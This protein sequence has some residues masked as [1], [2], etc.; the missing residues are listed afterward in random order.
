M[1]VASQIFPFFEIPNWIVRA[2]VLLL[3]LGFPVALVLAWAF[4]LTPEGMKGAEDV[5]LSKSIRRKT[6]RKL[7][8][9][10]IAVLLLVIGI[11]LF[12]RLH[13]NVSPAVSSS[14]QKSIAVLPFENLS[15]EKG[16]AYFAEGVQEEIL[17]R[18]SKIADLK[19]ISHTST[20]QF[21]SKPANLSE[22]A[23]EL[24]VVNLLEGSV[25]KIAH[26][27]P[28]NAQLIRAATDEHIWAE[29]YNRKLDDVFGVEGEVATAIADQLKAKLTG[30]E[31]KALTEK[32]TQNVA[33]YDAYLHGRSLE[34]EVYLFESNQQ[35]AA[36]YARAVQ[37]DPKFALAW[38]HLG[39]ARSLLFVSGEDPNIY[40]ATAVKQAAE[41]AM[42]LQPDLAEAWVALGAYRYRV[43]RDFAGALKAF[44]EGQK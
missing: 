3:I 23:K 20:Q 4:E 42:A 33:A 21:Q 17:T 26:E 35:P 41:E 8:F 22:I 6:G 27:V 2:V 15:E 16:N 28:M 30:A 24:G 1:Q 43:L 37:L 36:D 19:V 5:E 14:L 31:E 18:L 44:E 39:V 9:F 25:H 38:A 29:S 13:P 10:I 40:S 11:L 7:D 34:R 12:Q 32:P